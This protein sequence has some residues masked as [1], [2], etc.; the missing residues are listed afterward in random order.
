[1]ETKTK[2]IYDYFASAEFKTTLEQI[3]MNYPN[4]KQELFIRKQYKQ[5]KRA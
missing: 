3:N 2:I 5:M 4:L 1:M